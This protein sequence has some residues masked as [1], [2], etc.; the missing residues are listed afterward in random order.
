VYVNSCMPSLRKP[1]IKSMYLYGM[2]APVST[3]SDGI[4]DSDLGIQ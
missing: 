2:V 3:I 4:A 1:L